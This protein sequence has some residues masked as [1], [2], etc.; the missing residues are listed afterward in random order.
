MYES[1]L[2]GDNS[3][4][5]ILGGSKFIPLDSFMPDDAFVI[6][7][8][9]HK[10]IR[11]VATSMK[12]LKGGPRKDIF[13]NPDEVKVAI[14]TCGGLCPGLNVVIREIVM[15]LY[16]NYEV[17]EIYG[18]KWG[19]KGLY[20]DVKENWIKLRPHMVSDIHK[21]GGTILGSSRGGYDGDKIMDSLIKQGVNQVYIIGGDGTHR[22]IYALSQ[23]AEQRNVNISFCGVPKTIDNDIPIIDSSFGYVTCCAVAAQMIQAAYVE[24]TC[25][26]N[27]VGLIKLMGRH[28]GYIAL[29]ASLTQGQTDFCLIPEN[30]YELDGPNGLYQQIHDKIK[31]QGHA[32]IVVAEGAE[33]G[34]INPDERFTKAATKD[35]S[36]NVKL[37]DIGTILKDKIAEVMKTRFDLAINLK[38]VDPTYAIRSVPANAED[39]IKCA[40]LA[41]NA[42]HGAMAGYTAFSS[43]I[44]RN[45]VAFIPIKTIN[46]A[47]INQISVYDRAWQRLLGQIQQKEMV[48]EKFREAAKAKIDQAQKD[49]DDKFEAIKKR[50]LEDDAE[51][52][53]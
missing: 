37:D 29:N 53:A 2:M 12:F 34:L 4:K 9:E 18:I 45:A 21:L 27:G 30:P 48:N 10:T 39:T 49:R 52:E 50:I 44:V 23:L 6:Y 17:R 13:F 51:R 7:G 24:A 41:Q 28:S 3:E 22:G 36:G 19:Y 33:D 11:D 5:A 31:S 15:S 38:Y 42:V 20:T 47:G 1:P 35:G 46:Q 16:F 8:K 43:G 40:K 32:V 26:I 14:V 25:V